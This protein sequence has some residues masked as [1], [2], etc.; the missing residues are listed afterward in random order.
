M[1]YQFYK[2]LHIIGLI[3]VAFSFAIIA[4]QA[5]VQD[6]SKVK[7]TPAIYHGIGLLL[8]LVSG[9]GM[10]AKLGYISSLPVWI[11]VKIGLWLV[12]GVFV[13]VA[14]RLPISHHLKLL[15]SLLLMIAAA[16]MAIW[17]PL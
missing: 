2:T 3:L 11:H 6:W 7:K 14:K 10:A 9:F 1:S 15:I 8:L 17:K 5:F 12:L 4:V 16:G 13:A